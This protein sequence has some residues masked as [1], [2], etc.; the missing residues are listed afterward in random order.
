MSHDDRT[1]AVYDAK[2]ADY[3]DH[4]ASA[5]PDPHLQA[6]LAALPSSSRVLDVGCGPGQ[7]SAF[8]RTA[9]HRP[10]PVDASPAMVTLANDRHAIGARLASF[11]D[12]DALARYD[13]VWAN[14]SLLHA[15]RADLP[16][17]IA[18]IHKALK[19]QGIFH[20]ALKTGTGEGRDRLDR[21][22]TFV[23]RHEITDLLASAGFSL[24]A[25]HEGEERGLAG[26]L[27]PFIVLLA[28]A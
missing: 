12:L 6:F 22:Y 7:A 18:A 11:D 4:F 20:L 2:V 13:G 25:T 10:D 16:R 8:L 21:H 17:H 15:P 19:P 28:R 3:A 14:F 5:G 1:I 24:L 27:D 9:G 26:T 23:T